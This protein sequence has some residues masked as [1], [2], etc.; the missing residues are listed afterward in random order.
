MSI[1]TRV[2]PAWRRSH[3]RRDCPRLD[4]EAP[5]VGCDARP[6]GRPAC[7]SSYRIRHARGP[8]ACSTQQRFGGFGSCE[9]TQVIGPDSGKPCSAGTKEFVVGR[10]A[11]P[12]SGTHQNTSRLRSRIIGHLDGVTACRRGH[13]CRPSCSP[14]RA[15][16]RVAG[17]LDG[18]SSPERGQHAIPRAL[19]W[20]LPTG[21]FSYSRTGQ[22][23]DPLGAHVF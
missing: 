14:A 12:R 4:G 3:T 23:R 19:W 17:R 10:Q 5:H 8:G 7:F 13:R 16:P 6:A 21:R 2:S 9:A 22:R 15:F 1:V 18:L 20:E 11:D